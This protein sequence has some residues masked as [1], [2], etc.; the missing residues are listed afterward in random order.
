[1]TA[2]AVTLSLGAALLIAGVTMMQ[3][4]VPSSERR[5]APV[6]PLAPRL[7]PAPGGGGLAWTF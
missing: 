7:V 3:V 4:A 2:G 1:M 6:A 5:R